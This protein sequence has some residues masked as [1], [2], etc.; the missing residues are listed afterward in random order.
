MATYKDPVFSFDKEGRFSSKDN[1]IHWAKEYIKKLPKVQALE[2]AIKEA[3][4]NGENGKL[5]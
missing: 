2:K 5:V 1:A 3:R 4:D